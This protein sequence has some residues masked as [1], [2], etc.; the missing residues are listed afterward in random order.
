MHRLKPD[1]Y[2]PEATR[3]RPLHRGSGNFPEV[4]QGRG[5]GRDGV[6]R[7]VVT[8]MSQGQSRVPPPSSDQRVNTG[9]APV[10]A[11]GPGIRRGP[12]AGS[13]V[14]RSVRGGAEPP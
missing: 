10:L 12:G 8:A 13:T 9:T 3:T 2:G 6:L 11:P 1:G 7:V 4:Y 5:G 14:D